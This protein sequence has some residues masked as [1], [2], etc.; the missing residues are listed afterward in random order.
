MSGNPPTSTERQGTVRKVL[1]SGVAVLCAVSAFCAY[2]YYSARA[3]RLVEGK[4]LIVLNNAEVR[5]LALVDVHVLSASE[6]ERWYNQASPVAE[7]AIKES[8]A[9]YQ[10]IAEGL[11]AERDKSESYVVTSLKLKSLG[12]AALRVRKLQSGGSLVRND[13]TSSAAR[14][15]VDEITDGYGKLAYWFREDVKAMIKDQRFKEIAVATTEALARLESDASSVGRASELTAAALSREAS[16]ALRAV[17][18]A[19][20]SV[21]FPPSS[22]VR[23]AET[24]SDGD[25]HFSLKLPPGNY[26]VFSGSRR[27]LPGKQEEVFRWA[28]K[29][30]VK[31]DSDNSVILGNQNME[32]NS[33]DSLWSESFAARLESS[34]ANLKSIGASADVTATMM[35]SN[36]RSIGAD[37]QSIV[38]GLQPYK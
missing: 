8:V 37:R 5:K 35:K 33:V 13:T 25:G 15:G 9:E 7:K 36:A 14:R 28:V 17:E 23:V 27:Q 30:T 19:K 6:A 21:Y 26:I 2:T 4:V 3:D 22:F 29:L 11:K 12:E 24:I 16:E 10:R 20:A 32:S 34:I 1:L 18:R 31:S 38:V